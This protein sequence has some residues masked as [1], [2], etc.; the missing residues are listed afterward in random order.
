MLDFDRALGDVCSGW[1]ALIPPNREPVHV[2]AARNL[3]ISRPGGGAG[4]YKPHETAYMVKPMDTL[5][6]RRYSAV[7]FCG[8]AQTGKTLGLGEGW[9]TH[10]VVNDPGDMMIVQ[11]TQDKAREYSKQ[12]I[13]RAI[14]NSPK[15]REMRTSSSR[16]DNLHDKA[17]RN[18]MMLKIAWPTATNLSSTSYRYVFGTDYD[19]WPDNIDGEGDGFTLMGKRITTFLSRGMVAVESSPGRPLED[20]NWTPATPHEAPPVGGILGIYNRSD[21]QRL[22][23]KCPHCGEWFQA[24]PGLGLFQLPDEE[25]L[26]E[27]VRGID[28]D[29]F[30]RQYARVICPS[31]CVI[32]PDLRD[33]MNRAIL[34]GRGGW[35]QDGLTADNRDRISG[36]PRTSSIA[37]FWLGGVAA[38]YVNWETLLRK[39][40]QALLEYVLTSSELPLQTT[41]NTDQGLPYMS[42]HLVEAQRAAN[43]GGKAVEEVPRYI[44][45]DWARFVV[46]FVDVQGGA[47]AR[48]VV[49]VHAVGPHRE[50]QIIDR[51]A[52]TESERE[53][54]DGGKAP[55]DPDSYPEDWDVLTDKVVQATYRTSDPNREVKVFRTG[56]DT[57]G[58]GK[59]SP[60]A[61][62]WYRRL[63][64]LGLAPRV[65]LC[66]GYSGKADWYFRETKWGGKA[67]KGDVPGWLLEPN[68]L[69]DMVQDGLNRQRPGPGYY[70]IAPAK[71]PKHPDSWITPAFYD[72]LKAE[73][74]GAGGVWEQLK[75]RNEAFDCAAGINA[76]CLMHG[77]DRAGFWD[78]PPAWALPLD[79]GNSEVVTPEQRRAEKAPAAQ[80]APTEYVRRSRT[81]SY[82]GS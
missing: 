81:S 75:K 25:Q 41:L 42:R 10:A 57:G 22:Y 23:W 76:L 27:D 5:A 54:A 17:F 44:V 8:P 45:P 61:Y 9:L 67:G 66:K 35:L 14:R 4:L 59:V 77:T 70:H 52:I 49:Q 79:A 29:A 82:V 46:A 30:A 33:G 48:F 68:K 39:H 64:K 71:G 24:T 11:M 47:N 73:V 21:R 36:T 51:F 19:R 65:R 43:R 63:R 26:I 7:C 60:N 50:Q 80:Q 38:T 58:E 34:Q 62:A 40:M 28:I 72:E 31:G 15:L 56:V 53:G 2:G 78:N 12:R 55:L 37:G 3:Y 69:K 74:R 18:G 1:P 16:D 20:P 32:T 6:S 13:D